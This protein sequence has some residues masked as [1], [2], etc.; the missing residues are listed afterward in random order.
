L[1]NLYHLPEIFTFRADK[2]DEEII[3]LSFCVLI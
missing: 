2:G 1:K 3:S